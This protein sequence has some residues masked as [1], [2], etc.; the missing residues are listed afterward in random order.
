MKL[1]IFNIGEIECDE[2]DSQ[3]ILSCQLRF[4]GEGYVYARYKN[5]DMTLQ[6]FIADRA[7]I[8]LTYE[9]DHKDNNKLNFKRENLR[10]ATHTENNQ[11]TKY[12]KTSKTKIKGVDFNNG[13]Y[14]ARIRVNGLRIELGRFDS[15]IK[16]AEA[17]QIAS[18]KY[19][20]DFSKP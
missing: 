14:R 7:N 20:G 4:A 2:I 8:D 16:A 5:I 10:S 9:I 15:L 17:Y 11:N 19:H 6:R 12:K 18:N 13:K 3:F 1:L